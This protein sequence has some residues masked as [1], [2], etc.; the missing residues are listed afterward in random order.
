MLVASNSLWLIPALPLLGAAL[1][2]L[3]GR[4]LQRALGERAAGLPAVALSWAACAV[5]VAS[6]VELLGL[7]EGSALWSRLWPWFQV[8]PVGVDLAFAMDPLSAMMALVVTFVGSLI[9]V[10]SLGY[11][12]RDPAFWRFFAYLN[13]F[14]FSM[15]TL[16]LADNLLLMF[17]GWEGVGLCS[18]LLIG[19][20]YTEL[21]NARAGMKAFVVNRVGDFG[22]LIG[23]MIL[24]WSL[25]GDWTA[26]GWRPAGGASLT[27]RELPGL[28][29]AV[30]GKELWGVAVPTL[31]GLFL[32]LGATGKSAQI[33]L[34]VWLP[35][36]MAGPT[37]VSA[38]IHAATMV[39]AGVYMV[40]RMNFL[41]VLSPEAMTVVAV[42]GVGTALFAA[43]IGLLQHDIK[44][45]LAYS[46]VSQ[47]GFMFLGVG[48]GAFWAGS[49]HL[50]TH[51]FFKACLFLGAGSVILAMHHEQ[52]M[53]RMGGLGQVMPITRW[54]YWF[55]CVAISGFPIAA[56]FFSKD[57]ILWQAFNANSL[58]VPGWSLWL[59][60]ALTA[61]LTS[62]YMW[63]SYFLTF[64]GPLARLTAHGHDHAD[65][66]GH[67]DEPPE[68]E[69]QRP[70]ITVVLVVLAAGALLSS[71]LGLPEV[72]TEVHP[73]LEHFLAPV[74]GAAEGLARVYSPEEAHGLELALMLASVA[75]ATLGLGLAWWLYRGRKSDLP[76][77]LQARL[78]GL[79][80]FVYQKY[81]V[82][83]AYQA[84]FVLGTVSLSRV[85]AWF[86]LKV[87]D[88]LV[89]LTGV[90]TRAFAWVDGWIDQHLVDG[91]VDAVARVTRGAGGALRRL[92][93]GRLPSYLVGLALGLLLAAVLTR[94]L[95]DLAA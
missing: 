10:Y 46:T 58:Y 8:G 95:V 88:G 21:A 15:L 24:F 1:T 34:Y 5:A 28:M 77:R 57:E 47:L 65:G 55:A 50:L 93:T 91:L 56:G 54:T 6:F 23:L 78:P 14:M 62:F 18:Y 52:D 30:Q 48:V 92:Q 84:T 44:K 36:A 33:P 81:K 37:P 39:T 38:L 76:A 75:V 89:N 80:G 42:V 27:F 17:V 25:G 72:L 16:V 20:W 68:P 61:G 32:F 41:Y 64:T 74:F 86:D 3:F 59:V 87:I 35:D 31:A 11:M 69:E 45:V 49:Y 19:F 4:G 13:L 73:T 60:G 53:R 67:V 63:R 79:H 26:S 29:A 22:F 85:L 9:H 82:D 90:L 43:T 71:F 2:F 7:P 66:H 94:F 83:E 51:A 12:H 70:V 40:A